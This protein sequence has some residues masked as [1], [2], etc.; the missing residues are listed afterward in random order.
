MVS[1]A[2]ALSGCG[3]RRWRS[4]QAGVCWPLLPPRV[5][6]NF[7]RLNIHDLG[8]VF[9]NSVRLTIKLCLCNRMTKLLQVSAYGGEP[10]FCAW[11]VAGMGDKDH[12]NYQEDGEHHQNTLLEVAFEAS[13]LKFQRSTSNYASN[14]IVVLDIEQRSVATALRYDPIKSCAAITVVAWSLDSVCSE[15]LGGTIEAGALNCHMASMQIS[16]SA[17]DSIE[18]DNPK[19]YSCTSCT[20]LPLSDDRLVEDAI[21]KLFGLCHRRWTTTPSSLI[22]RFNSRDSLSSSSVMDI[23]YLQ[24]NSTPC[25]LIPDRLS[26][27]PPAG[28]QLDRTFIE[29]LEDYRCGNFESELSTDERTPYGSICDLQHL[30]EFRS[31]SCCI[32]Q[33]G[34]YLS[35]SNVESHVMMYCDP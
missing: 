9:D 17:I 33:L 5:W 3:A 15:I 1:E 29:A 34:T 18:H 26:G 2:S 13:Y 16:G 22:L 6:E 25:V 28:H 8:G 27:E 35:C 20:C 19:S 21:S 30:H 4:E 32:V 12:A 11:L 10:L 23:R 24:L 14:I 7:S 31:T